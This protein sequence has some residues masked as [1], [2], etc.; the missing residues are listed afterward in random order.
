MIL[1]PL[2]VPVAVKLMPLRVPVP[3]NELPFQ[4]TF[5]AG[6]VYPLALTVKEPLPTMPAAAGA[7]GR[8]AG[9]TAG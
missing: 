7:T 9:R 2:A 8:G 6:M 1:L 3:E 4:R 5:E